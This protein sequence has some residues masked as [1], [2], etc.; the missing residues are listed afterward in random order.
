MQDFGLNG[1]EN[2]MERRWMNFYSM[3]K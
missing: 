3:K 1:L 2:E